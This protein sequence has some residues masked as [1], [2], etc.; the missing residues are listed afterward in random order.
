MHR[1]ARHPIEAV[2]LVRPF[3]LHIVDGFDLASD[4]DLSDGTVL[5]VGTQGVAT[6]LIVEVHAID[7]LDG[8]CTPEDINIV[9]LPASELEVRGVS[10]ELPLLTPEDG[11][12]VEG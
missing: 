1:R 10:R 12:A 6:H 2:V 11:L 4:D 8:E 3:I 5:Y 7:V 9:E